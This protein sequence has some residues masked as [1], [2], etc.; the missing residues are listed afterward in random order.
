MKADKTIFNLDSVHIGFMNEQ[1]P[2]STES[3]ETVSYD[4]SDVISFCLTNHAATYR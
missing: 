3:H 2:R 1:K 4:S